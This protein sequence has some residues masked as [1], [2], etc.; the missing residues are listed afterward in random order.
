MKIVVVEDEIRIREGICN[1]IEKMFREHEIVGQGE[2]GEE[3]LKIV[4]ETQPDLI[5]TDIKMPC[6][7]GLEML[8]HMHNKKLK[9]KA[10]V[11]SAYSEFSY[12]QKA[13][14][15]GISEYLL[16]P[17]VV[18]EFVQ[19][20]KAIEN[21]CEEEKKENPQILG[22]MENILFGIIAGGLELNEE[23]YQFLEI[24]YGFISN[25]TF[26]QIQIYM[27]NQYEEK[28]NKTKREIEGLLNEKKEIRYSI[29]E[30]PKDKIML[31]ILYGCKDVNSMERWFQ[32][33]ILQRKNRDTWLEGLSF[34]W[35]NVDGISNLKAASQILT[36]HMEWN[37][38]LGEAVIISYPKILNVQ[39]VPCTY[40]IDIEN[41]MKVSM[42][43]YDLDDIKNQIFKFIGYFTRGQVYS[44]KE[45]KESYVRFLWA[46]INVAKEIGAL[47]SEEFEQQRII[48]MI[49]SAVNNEELQVVC[50]EVFKSILHREKKEVGPTTL[51]VNRAVGMIKEFYNTGI[52]LDEM[53]SKL[54]ITPEYLGT[55]FH[56]E[57]GVNFSAYIKEIRIKKAKEL[58]LSSNMKLYEISNMVGYADAKYF[59]RVFKECTGQLPG[60]YRKTN[61]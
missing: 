60:Q 24:K 53:A 56:K 46:L 15:L 28:Y 34:G 13:I 57:M 16:K 49:M 14:K 42:C 37:I 52:T 21:Q 26:S 54:N 29:I 31:I 40:P 20:I 11:L 18:S 30:I 44:P 43:T 9:T 2:N 59:S 55:Q 38:A 58:L 12:A 5:I 61:K 6:M 51:I 3:G 27:G 48:K 39:T 17:I 22:G 8:T 23:L 19:S 1:L 7:D 25:N 35:I 50:G 10:I 41:K 47:N 45:I 4:I 33:C 32:N 36:K